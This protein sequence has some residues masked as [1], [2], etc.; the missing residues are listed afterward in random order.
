MSKSV[1]KKIAH[2][3]DDALE[4]IV[5]ELRKAGESV[6]E[7]AKENFSDA[8]AKLR[9]AA[10]VFLTEANGKSRALTQDAVREVKAHPVEAAAI[11][12]AA[13]ALIGLLIVRR[14]Q[15]AA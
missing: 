9:E 1:T 13:A 7:D 4:D 3:L 8:A 14:A 6:S 11:A 12:A 2:T 15:V 10:E 5:R